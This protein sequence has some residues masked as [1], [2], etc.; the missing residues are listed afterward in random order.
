[1]DDDRRDDG[2]HASADGRA[3]AEKVT[4][5][6]HVVHVGT[7]VHARARQA[8]YRR[9]PDVHVR[10][11]EHGHDMR[12]SGTSRDHDGRIDVFDSRNPTSVSKNGSVPLTA[13][14]AHDDDDDDDD[15]RVQDINDVCVDVHQV[16]YTCIRWLLR[17]GDRRTRIH[18]FFSLVKTKAAVL[19]VRSSYLYIYSICARILVYAYT[20][21]WYVWMYM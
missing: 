8:A 14:G 16:A 10:A 15:V 21:V 13:E 2:R 1:L 19:M 18:A 4:V 5:T 7:N 12:A 17:V 3:A 6:G 9:R 20:R 11:R